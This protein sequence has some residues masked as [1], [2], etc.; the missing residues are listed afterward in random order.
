MIKWAVDENVSIFTFGHHFLDDTWSEALR[1]APTLRD[2]DFDFF[3]VFFDV[4]LEI[5]FAVFFAAFFRPFFPSGRTIS[6]P[7]EEAVFA[8]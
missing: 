5:P 8:N 4:F 7:K 2:D 6:K 1:T 3:D